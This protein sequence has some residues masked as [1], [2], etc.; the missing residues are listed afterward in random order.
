MDPAG[1]KSPAKHISQ[2]EELTEPCTSLRV[3]AAQSVHDEA[4]IAAL[5]Y[6][7]AEQSTHVAEPSPLALPATHISQSEELAEPCTSLWV[8]ATQGMHSSLLLVPLYL[9]GTQSSHPSSSAFGCSLS[10]QDVLHS[11]QKL[12]LAVLLASATVIPPSWMFH[13]ISL[14]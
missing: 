12:A 3:P 7:P 8:P 4:P 6:L 10:G 1:Q 11:M 9:P 14:V 13:E 5:A 2:S